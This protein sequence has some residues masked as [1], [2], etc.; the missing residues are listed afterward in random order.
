[1]MANVSPQ[2]STKQ[3]F[4]PF[5]L[6]RK[7]SVKGE[8]RRAH[9]WNGDCS[10]LRRK[11]KR[12]GQVASSCHG[13]QQ[14]QEQQQQQ[15]QQQKQH[16][17][18]VQL[19]LHAEQFAH[20][21]ESRELLECRLRVERAGLECLEGLASELS[22]QRKAEEQAG[23]AAAGELEQRRA[24][25]TDLLQCF[26]AAL[27][28]GQKTLG[29]AVSALD[30]SKSRLQQRVDDAEVGVKAMEAEIVAA[31]CAT[32]QAQLV[33]S[34]SG[35]QVGDAS[36]ETQQRSLLEAAGVAHAEAKSFLDKTGEKLSQAH[37]ERMAT[38]EAL[39]ALGASCTSALGASVLD[40]EKRLD[41][42]RKITEKLQ[43]QAAV[44]NVA[45]QKACAET[46][47]PIR[48]PERLFVVAPT[49]PATAGE[50]RLMTS[51][52]AGRPAYAQR[53]LN[54]DGHSSTYLF[55]MMLADSR[56]CC[57]VFGRQLPETLTEGG[58]GKEASSNSITAWQEGN[59]IARS[60]QPA[61]TALPDELCSTHWNAGEEVVAITVIGLGA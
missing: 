24:E 3:S 19:Q 36:V 35:F 38:L 1:M 21:G 27:A 29:E 5:S 47:L 20:G 12:S 57:W 55:W 41:A 39:V 45:N 43:A 44:V 13:V 59:L 31:D 50:Y 23:E 34:A 25:G 58:L 16:P 33:L 54:G 26:Q 42:E 14:Q 52:V 15:Q 18:Q 9:S 56:R 61:W 6:K 2:T 53:K 7:P 8:S 11:R 51:K 46:L 49:L 28:T 40:L 17:A 48:Q 22:K 60:L 37:A 32:K 30:E 4:Q 10:A